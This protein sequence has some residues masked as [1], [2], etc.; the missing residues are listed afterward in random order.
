[1]LKVD[2]LYTVEVE[3][4]RR[5]PALTG[6]NIHSVHFTPASNKVFIP[7]HHKKKFYDRTVLKIIVLYKKRINIEC[8]CNRD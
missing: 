5:T 6:Y 1:M 3:V 8:I 4:F 7:P 2:T